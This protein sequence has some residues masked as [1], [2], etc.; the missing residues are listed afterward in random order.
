M[1]KKEKKQKKDD[2]TSAW[3]TIRHH[4]AVKDDVVALKED[5]WEMLK[6]SLSY[7]EDQYNVKDRR[8]F[9]YTYETL[10]ELLDAMLKLTRCDDKIRSI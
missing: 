10:V 9:I 5:L 1:A 3:T 6:T 2:V 7:D 8:N 4:C